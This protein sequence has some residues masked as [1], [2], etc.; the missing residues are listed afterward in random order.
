MLRRE[1]E[2]ENIKFRAAEQFRSLRTNIEFKALKAEVKSIVVTSSMPGEGKSTVVS[3]LGA[4]LASNGKRVAIV[5][6]DLRKPAIHKKF[7][8]HNNEGL[9]NILIQNRKFEDVIITSKIPNLFVIP[10]GPII[11][12]PSELLSSDNMKKLLNE[13]T[14]SFNMILIDTPP[15]FQIS[16][17]LILSALAKGTIIVAAYRKS[18]KNVLKNTKERI[19]KVGGNILGVV[20]NKIPDKNSEKFCD[21]YSHG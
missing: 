10:G 12:N 3:N 2:L 11:P 13:L 9:S 15:V 14:D 16:D 19:E 8:M 5:D 1:I 21:Y 6:C 4:S 20:I 7:L 18:E 17:A